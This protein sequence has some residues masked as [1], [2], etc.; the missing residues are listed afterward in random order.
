MTSASMSS[1]AISAAI[2]CASTSG[3]SLNIE[4]LPRPSLIS[5]SRGRIVGSSSGSVLRTLRSGAYRR[6][7]V[8]RLDQRLLFEHRDVAAAV[9][10]Q[11]QQ[12]ADRRVAQQLRLDDLVAGHQSMCQRGGAADG[13]LLEAPPRERDAGR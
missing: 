12:G 2:F 11:H 3:S 9:A 10:D 4:M 1:E 13:Q 6:R 8:L 5:T 7:D